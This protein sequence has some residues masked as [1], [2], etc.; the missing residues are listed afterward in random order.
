MSMDLP[1]YFFR[2]RENGAQVFQVHADNRRQR[3]EMTQIAVVNIKNNRFKPHADRVLS[4]DDITAIKTW[5]DDRTAL[6]D[7]RELDDIRRTLDHLHHTTQW[8]QTKATDAELD[9]ITDDLL[10]TMHDLRNVLIKK[11]SDRVVGKSKKMG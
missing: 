3:V 4:D 6:L 10:L 5:M 7:Q 11:K 9:A 2:T 8:A 1:K